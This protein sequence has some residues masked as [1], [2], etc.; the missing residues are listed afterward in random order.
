MLRENE[1]L[2]KR[3]TPANLIPQ[4]Y[5]TLTYSK[6]VR[7]S[8]F[9]LVSVSDVCM[10]KMENLGHL[11]NCCS[12][13]VGLPNADKGN[14]LVSTLDL[15]IDSF[16]WYRFPQESSI[17]IDSWLIFRNRFNAD[18]IKWNRF[19]T[20]SLQESKESIPESILRNRYTSLIYVMLQI[21]VTL[22]TLVPGESIGPQ[23]DLSMTTGPID[24][25][26]SFT[27]CSEK[28]I[29]FE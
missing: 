11:Q 18:S 29:G 22:R 28:P 27:L 2:K 1:A 21:L 14:V 16:K 24:F 23:S 4:F 10:T 7:L 25:G 26:Q 12:L 17:R 8:L 19:Q 15:Y 9:C 6:S 20:D 13:R 3:I 5:L